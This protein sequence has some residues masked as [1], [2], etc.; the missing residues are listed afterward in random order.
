MNSGAAGFAHGT[1]LVRSRLLRPEQQPEPK[2]PEPKQPD[3]SAGSGSFLKMSCLWVFLSFLLSAV[4]SATLGQQQVTVKL[5]QSVSLECLGPTDEEVLLFTWT[6][7]GLDSDHLFFYRNGRSYESYQHESFRGRVD[8]RSSLEDGDFSVVLHNVSRTDE[9][10]FHCVIVTKRSGG[11]SGN[12]QSFVNLTVSGSDEEQQDEDQTG[13]AGDLSHENNSL[14]FVI[15]SVLLLILII[16]VVII[17]VIIG[18]FLRKSP[19]LSKS[20]LNHSVCLSTT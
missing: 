2:Q 5:G 14:P 1:I 15:V 4:Y 12:L 11:Q 8:L 7:V 13:R 10:T 17:V 20:R 18:C 19:V 6:K 16:I 9:G 3:L